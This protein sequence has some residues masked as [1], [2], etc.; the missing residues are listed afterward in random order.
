[1]ISQFM[2]NP[3][4][5]HLSTAYRVLH[6]LKGTPGKGIMFKRNDKLILKT[7]TNAGY[8]GSMEDKNSTI[9][10]C[11]FLGSNVVIGGVKNKI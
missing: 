10:H 1:M 9:D 3:K 2:Y 7:Y 4:E 6:Y 11:T 5:V 8:T